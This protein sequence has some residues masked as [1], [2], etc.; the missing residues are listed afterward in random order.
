MAAFHSSITN[1]SYGW[2]HGTQIETGFDYCYF[3][4]QEVSAMEHH[5]IVIEQHK[6]PEAI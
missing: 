5:Q 4:I 1:L 2:G 3:L 6:P